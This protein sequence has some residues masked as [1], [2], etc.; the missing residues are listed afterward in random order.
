MARQVSYFD[1]PA[2]APG[3]R[4]RAAELRSWR[5]RLRPASWRGV[6]FFVGEASGEV[7]RRYEMHEY[8]QRDQPWAED[9]GRSQRKWSV[10]GYVLG[11]DYMGTRDR[12]LAACE[13]SGVGKLVHPYLG[14]LHVVCDR[15]RYTERDEEGRICRFE[16][17]FAEPGTKGAPTARRAAGAALQGAAAGLQAAAV[18]AF[19]G[20]L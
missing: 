17:S 11:D 7:G 4:R 14:E 5:A 16:L 12:L 9:L 2:R 1:G 15:F 3:R 6:P 13:Q 20:L 8:P 18:S 10:T 19:A